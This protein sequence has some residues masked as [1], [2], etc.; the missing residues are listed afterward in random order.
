MRSL[1]RSAAAWGLASLMAPA[2]WA[3]NAADE[4][5]W[6]VSVGVLEDYQSRVL[7]SVTSDESDLVSHVGA[8]VAHNH[9]GQRLQLNI[10]ANGSG[11]FYHNLNNLNRFSYAGGLDGSYVASPRLRFTFVDVLTD[12]YTYD[13]TVLVENGIL[14]PL[15]HSLSNRALGGMVYQL[16]RR[17]SALVN[18]RF[19]SVRFDSSALVS[20]TQLTGTAEI[21]RQV[22]ASHSFG[23]AYGINRYSNRERITYFNTISGTWVMALARR[24]EANASVGVG[25]L[26]D[27]VVPA[28][29]T[30]LVALAGLNAHFQR[31]S[32]GARYHRSVIPAYGLGRNQLVDAVSIDYNNELSRT[33]SF[34]AI[35]SLATN[36]DPYNSNVRINSQN[37]LADL[38]WAVTR[39]LSLVGG[40]TY[41]SRNAKGPSPG[42]HSNGA[43]VYFSYGHKW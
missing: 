20:G 24:L 34:V 30:T 25:F 14:L 31:S 19:D 21:R 18:G 17:T 7:M 27:S 9:K 8:N 12:A 33:L 41:R 38:S 5:S 6:S 3:Q 2:L 10:T 4:P 22:S 40:Y 1:S 13:H 16:S 36:A 29:Q 42:I 28:N 39:R 23:I 26:E 35:A 15:V 11:L 32:F 43:H 37:H